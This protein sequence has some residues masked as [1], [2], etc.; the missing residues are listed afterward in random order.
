MVE[1]PTGESPFLATF[2]HRLGMVAPHFI[3]AARLTGSKLSV[4]TPRMPVTV[5]AGTR[6]VYLKPETF[7]DVMQLMRLSV[8]PLF[9]SINNVFCFH[10]Q[11]ARI[12]G[13]KGKAKYVKVVGANAKGIL[14][15][16]KYWINVLPIRDYN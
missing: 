10:Y 11:G 4:P 1:T 15:V 3:F 6:L 12:D 14:G 8:R 16:V 2:T 5:L 7:L 13:L 9:L